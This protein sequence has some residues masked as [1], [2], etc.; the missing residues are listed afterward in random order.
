MLTTAEILKKVRELD[1]KSKRLTRHLFTGEYHSAFKGRGMSF[2]EVRE[3]AAGD[4][5]RFIDWNVSARFNHPFSKLFEEERELTV[6]LLVDVSASSL[7]GTVHARKK[8]LI[9]EVCAVLAF[10]AINNQDKVGV[11]FFSD[12]VEAYIPPKKGREHVL[13]IVRQLL[14]IEPKH[15]GTNLNEV[16]RFF[17][18]SARQKAIVFMLSDFLDGNGSAGNSRSGLNFE[19]ALKVAGKKHDLIGIKV[20]DRMD[21]QLPEIGMIEAED[22]ETGAR[23]WVDTDDYLVRTNYQQ[24][25]FN[26]TEQCKT[27]FQKAGCDLLHLRTDEDYVKILQRFFVGRHRP[28]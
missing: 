22:S 11:V 3:Y 16:I 24:Y 2:R 27:I 23:Y 25:F 26:Q 5:I 20:Y 8:D 6:L 21:M 18:H 14:T 17:N 4:D 13:F 12:R 28:G 19:D 7:F 15:R 1:I 10:S 9:T